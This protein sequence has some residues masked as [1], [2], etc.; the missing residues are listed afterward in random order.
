MIKIQRS[1][2][3]E[4]DAG[5][6]FGLI[7]DPARYP[8]FFVGITKWELCSEKRH[9]LGATFR[10]LMQVGPIEAG[11]VVKVTDWQEPTT[12]AWRSGRGTHL[13]GRWTVTPHEDGS[14]DLALEIGYDLAGGPIGL[15][16]ERIVG[17]IVGGNMQASLLAA[18]RILTFDEPAQLQKASSSSGSNR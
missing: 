16:V 3:V 5:T 14:S 8:D 11:G 15:L 12:I 2:E 7:D 13:Q 6:V 4:R 17:R 9:G 10:V 18:R 1:I